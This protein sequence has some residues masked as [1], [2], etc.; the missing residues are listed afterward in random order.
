MTG[1]DRYPCTTHLDR[2]RM[3]QP[4]LVRINSS[5][6]VPLQLACGRVFS[7][8]R[9]YHARQAIACR[10]IRYRVN[11][12]QIVQETLGENFWS[13]SHTENLWEVIGFDARYIIS[14][15]LVDTVWIE[16]G[17]L[18]ACYHLLPSESVTRRR[19][20]RFIVELWSCGAV[21][22]QKSQLVPRAKG[23]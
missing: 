21:K 6:K 14:F 16:A 15:W 10:L 13:T 2:F 18:N 17:W 12:N 1:F 23:D 3:K 20:C 8:I 9:L 11:N 5:T 7:H 19:V 22:I 4:T